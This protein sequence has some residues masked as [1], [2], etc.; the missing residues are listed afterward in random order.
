MENKDKI[1][2]YKE[3]FFDLRTFKAPTHFVQS[4]HVNNF[5]QTIQ[6]SISQGIDVK[7]HEIS[8]DYARDIGFINLDA[9]KQF[10]K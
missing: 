6:F 2:I 10:I 3:G 7:T 8:M 4:I 1:L 5:K 9:L